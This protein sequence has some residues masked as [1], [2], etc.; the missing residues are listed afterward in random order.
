MKV[1][2]FRDVTL[3][4]LQDANSGPAAFPY[5]GSLDEKLFGHFRFG[6]KRVRDMVEMSRTDNVA[7]AGRS[8]PRAFFAGYLFSAYGHFLAES[9]HR[10]WPLFEGTGYE[11]IPIIFQSFPRYKERQHQL[12]PFQKDILRYLHVDPD[13]V[14]LVNDS[15]HIGELYVPEQTKWLKDPDVDRDYFKRFKTFGHPVSAGRPDGNLYVSRSGYMFSGSLLG[16]SLVEQVLAEAGIQVIRPEEWRFPDLIE[17]YTSKS[18]IAMVE[19]SVL[20]AFEITGGLNA[21]LLVLSRRERDAF[22]K[23][24]AHALSQ[25]NGGYRVLSRHHTL[26]PL[27]TATP[28]RSPIVFDIAEFLS[29]LE[30]F[31]E[32]PIRIPDEAELQRAMLFDLAR[33]IFDSRATVSESEEEIGAQFVKLRN[34]VQRLQVFGNLVK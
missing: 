11:D 10:L 17:L 28:A 3:L 1:E 22:E 29:E 30:T 4:P 24:F 32:T 33:C 2:T 8:Y 25:I 12:L 19:G 6:P 9:I 27:Q 14:V 20:H 15:T 34:T 31:Y 13:R 26:P 23:Q 16:E 21:K 7:V 5:S 18:R